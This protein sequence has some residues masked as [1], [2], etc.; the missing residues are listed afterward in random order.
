RYKPEIT[1]YMTDRTD[2]SDWTPRQADYYPLAGYALGY[3]HKDTVG[4]YKGQEMR[5]WG[6]TREGTEYLE[7]IDSN[8]ITKAQTNLNK[9]IRKSAII[10]R[11][12]SR[13]EEEGSLTRD[14]IVELVIAESEVNETTAHRRVST[15]RNWLMNLSE[16][17]ERAHGHSTKY[18]Y[19]SESLD[20][21]V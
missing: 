11:I 16:I 1:S 21:Y 14:D 13:L 9:H 7:I 4:D 15:L 6:L 8:D 3:V 20:D 2:R 10:T 18:E 17:N 12:L 5:R 19:I